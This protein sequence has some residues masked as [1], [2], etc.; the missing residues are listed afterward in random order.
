MRVKYGE[1]KNEYALFFAQW[2]FQWWAT[3][4]FR[5]PV[6]QYTARKELLKWTRKL[7]VK[8]RMQIAYVAVFNELH[9]S[10]LHVVML[11]RNRFGQTL[12]DVSEEDWCKHWGAN[13]L[14]KP[15]NNLMGASCYLSQ[16]VTLQNTDKWDLLFYNRKLLKKCKA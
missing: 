12:K 6:N 10:H 7:C 11:G 8:E 4:S 9:R 3:L 14:I 2:P 15:V 5:I 13:A 16:N 1:I